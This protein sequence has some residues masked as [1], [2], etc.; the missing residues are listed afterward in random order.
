MK[1]YKIKKDSKLWN[2]FLGTL[3]FFKQD[4][5]F[6]STTEHVRFISPIYE[7]NFELLEKK[8]YTRCELLDFAK[9]VWYNKNLKD[10]TQGPN[11]YFIEWEKAVRA[12]S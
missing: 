12:K 9:Y 7:H 5:W 3:I 8:E 11:T 4:Y 10:Y 1:K 2:E 6:I